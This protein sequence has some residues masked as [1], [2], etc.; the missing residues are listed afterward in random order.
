[1]LAINSLWKNSQ[2]VA[3][4]LYFSVLGVTENILTPQNSGLT[5]AQ[6]GECAALCIFMALARVQVAS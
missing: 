2:L 4:K 3:K 5:K 1:M 6:L